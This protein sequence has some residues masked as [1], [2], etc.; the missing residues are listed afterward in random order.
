MDASHAVPPASCEMNCESCR[1]L[2]LHVAVPLEVVIVD[3]L[4]DVEVVVVG[5]TDLTLTEELRVARQEH[6]ELIREGEPAHA[7]AYEGRPVVAVL[8]AAV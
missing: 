7:V 1:T 8:M 2:G 4:E 3:V 6:A 5:T